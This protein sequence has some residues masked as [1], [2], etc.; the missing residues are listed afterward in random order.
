LLFHSIELENNPRREFFNQFQYKPETQVLKL[1]K[2]E[3][4]ARASGFS[5]TLEPLACASGLYFRVM[6]LSLFPY[7]EAVVEDEQQANPFASPEVAA[8]GSIPQI[9]P[10]SEIRE[11]HFGKSFIKWLLICAISGAPSFLI[12][13]GPSRQAKI[14]GLAM[15][16]GILTYV[17]FY[18][19]VESREWTRRKL[20][21]K[22]LRIAVKTGYISRVAI[23]ILFPVGFFVD[24][25][26]G[27]ISVGLVSELSGI[28]L[29]GIGGKERPPIPSMPIAFGWYYTTTMLQGLL[30][31]IVLG[32]YT[33]IVYALVLLF[34]KGS[35]T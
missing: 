35:K 12:A 2:Y 13:L 27:M 14:Q 31:N 19:F 11:F 29:M 21:D 17:A 7:V 9:D 4:E 1:H 20:T 10:N 8:I 32:A 6:M 28:D 3:P 30:L 26:C 18:V 34:R 5:R 22:S 25:I 15:V 24:M 23:S 16:C 33:L